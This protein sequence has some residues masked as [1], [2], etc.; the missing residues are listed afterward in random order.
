MRIREL[1]D[2]SKNIDRRIEKV[3]T[4]DTTDPE[5]LRQ[6]IMEYVATES[7]EASFERLLDQLDEGL[8][9]GGGH[10]IGVW[11][12]G[13][14]GSGKSS[15]TKYLGFALDPARTLD[16]KPFLDW[17]Q[18][19]FTSQPLRARLATIA[20][21]H[22]STV[23]MLDLASE[24]LA[25]AAMME[26]SSVLYS[27]VMQ[28]AGYSQDRKVA[29][30]EYM[31]E[32][33]GRLADFEARIPELAKGKTWKQI[34]NQPLVVKTLAS[35]LA[36][37]FYPDIWPDA[38]AFNEVIL[39][40]AVKEDDRVREMID[41]VR[42]RSGR[43]NIFFI[44]D[45]VGQYAAARDALILNL[46]GLAKNLKN[47]GGGRVWILATAQQTLTEDDPRAHMNTAKLFKL[48]DRFPVPID[49]EASDIKEICT[50]RLLGKSKPGEELLKELF[51]SKGQALRFATQLVNTRY[52]KSD[53]DQKTFC[54][55]YPFLPQHFD[56]LLEL[57]SRLAKTSGGIGLRSAI[58]V[59]QDVLV[60]QSGVRPG[61]MLLADQE[62]G[63]LATTVVLYNTLRRDIQRSFRHIVEGVEKVQTAFGGDSVHARAAKSIAVLQVLEDFPVSRENL[64]AL[65][66]PSVDSPSLL[67]QVKEAVEDLLKD[68]AIPL[69]EIDGSLRFMSEAVSNLE[70]E[71]LNIPWKA[72]DLRNVLNAKLR[73]V[74]TPLPSSLLLGTRTVNAGVKVI[75][76]G[77]TV[78]LLGEKEEIQTHLEF[79][80]EA[81]YEVRRQEL[82]LESQQRASRNTIFLTGI[83]DPEIQNLTIEIFRCRTIYNQ[84]RNKTVEKEITDYLNG[85]LQ[86]AET[87]SDE[88]E[89]RLVKAL[90]RGS[91]LFRGKPS[92][93]SELDPDVRPAAKEFLK[94][95]AEEV[96]EK[97][98]EAPVQVDS[99][100]AERFLKTDQLDKMA[101]KDD[102]LGLV[103]K[104]G[105]TTG[106]D[107]G[108]KALVSLKDYL[109]KYGQT[110]G[111]KLLDDFYSSPCGW[112][113]DTTR[114][115]VAALLVAGEIKLRISGQDV[116]VR[117][118]VAFESLK[119]T[120]NFN[121]IG[122]ALRSEGK[123]SPESLLRASD[124][125]LEL[126]GE[127][128]LPLEEVISKAVTKHFPDFQQ[129]FAPLAT[130]LKNLELSGVELAQS[131][132]DSISEILKGDASDA[133]HRLGCEPC[134]LYDN[135]IWARKV[136]KAFDNGIEAI[137][138]RVKYYL[139]GI[140][141]L[142]NSGIP[143]QLIHSTETT[144]Q[145]LQELI[146]RNDFFDT[147][148]ELQTRLASLELTVESAALDLIADEEKWLEKEKASL[149]RLKEWGLLAEDDRIAIAGQLDGLKIMAPADLKG[150]QKII[151]D[152]YSLM[153]ELKFVEEDIKARA[154]ARGDDDDTGGEGQDLLSVDFPVPILVN[155][156]E[157]IDAIIAELESL[158]AKLGLFSRLRIHWKLPGDN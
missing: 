116:T 18:N 16:G 106:I 49:L 15:F 149:Q 81:S 144:R 152:H 115:L 14:Y 51:S 65:M 69:S 135:L 13:F 137:I 123:P 10:E 43:E 122:I 133:T 47:L 33:D 57:L 92:P 27:K 66:H 72:I 130:Q 84:N 83:E 143:A 67:P 11:V 141:L 28:W 95:V 142:P 58:K 131:I 19:R 105:K 125:L 101:S 34:H 70:K 61:E 82:L 25:G 88:L 32:R 44:I 77:L 68:P 24:Q 98:G 103:K 8:Q 93:V 39:D 17:L 38:K 87:L 148:P 64:A 85:Q 41:L 2:P 35:R 52:Y 117:G 79:V 36:S 75:S 86:R 108:H 126:T 157:E 112:S 136:K 62:A 5:R 54:D 145:G 71:R 76:G 55:L 104:V 151:N 124:R 45:E 9:G 127:N 158:K 128:V 40:E 42:R 74:F 80:P 147:I 59:I 111:K 134:P 150:I 97:Y 21:R 60:D 50:R 7:I 110:D 78:S 89:N 48:K 37:E 6:E 120:I 94:K 119:N 113:K 155:S 53:L 153:Q 46:D 139:N 154:R 29:Y 102:P 23:I 99:T 138:K 100:L 12:S 1:F 63:N 31:L 140:P 4:Y 146:N 3:I 107:L 91:F 109:E 73:D 20:K 96:F 156:Q 129:D 30:L 90:S 56:I 22:P 26:I 114:Y 121:K 132:Q 118:Q